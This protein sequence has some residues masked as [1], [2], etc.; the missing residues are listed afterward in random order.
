MLRGGWRT[1]LQRQKVNNNYPL[2]SIV[3]V[4]FNSAEDLKKTID[5]ISIQSYKNMEHIIIDG[6]STDN[7]SSI[8]QQYNDNIAYW[9][10]EPDDGIYDAM[11][12]G[13]KLATGDYVLFLNSGDV[14]NDRD[15]L[16]KVFTNDDIL[17][18]MPLIIMGKVDC[19]Y[20]HQHYWI[21]KLNN[22]VTVQYSPPHQAMFIKKDIYTQ[23]DY[24]KYFRILGDRDYWL[25]LLQDD[26]YKIHFVNEVISK[27]SLN[28]VSSNPKN[29][30]TMI[31]EIMILNCFYLGYID[32][33]VLL[34]EA[35]KAFIKI[36]LLYIVG[37]HRYYKFLAR[38]IHNK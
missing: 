16:E 11:N 5:S 36:I 21:S 38:F 7:T 34:K 18:E 19:E 37:T 35:F 6:G 4:T 31:R 29:A 25:R 30:L 17:S 26:C 2:I 3:T 15:I 24:N 1:G 9:I 10:S 22:T 8:L 33:T 13:Q 28:G 23:Y 20:K 12:K 32:L 27:Y 14:F